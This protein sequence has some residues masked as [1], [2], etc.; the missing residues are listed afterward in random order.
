MTSEL[1]HEWSGQSA[2]AWRPQEFEYLA[3]KYL[4]KNPKS[5]SIYSWYKTKYK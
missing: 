2:T 4:T 3:R 1:S 5:K